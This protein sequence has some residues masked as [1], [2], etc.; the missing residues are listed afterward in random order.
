MVKFIRRLAQYTAGQASC[1]FHSN[2]SSA[3]KHWPCLRSGNWTHRKPSLL[4]LAR[5]KWQLATAA[6]LVMAEA[7]AED[8][9]PLRSCT[10]TRTSR[11]TRPRSN[12]MSVVKAAQVL[13]LNFESHSLHE[14]RKERLRRRYARQVHL[15]VV[16]HLRTAL[17][18][19]YC[20]SAAVGLAKPASDIFVAG[21]LE[22]Y[23]CILCYAS[24]PQ[25]IHTIIE[26]MR[27]IPS[28]LQAAAH[29][30][31]T[32][33]HQRSLRFTELA[34]LSKQYNWLTPKSLCPGLQGGDHPH[35]TS[36]ALQD[37]LWQHLLPQVGPRDLGSLACTCKAAEQL[38]ARAALEKWEEAANACLP[39]QH[40]HCGNNEVRLLQCALI[41]NSLKVLI[42]RV[43][44]ASA[45]PPCSNL[46]LSTA[47][48]SVVRVSS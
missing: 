24:D 8:A 33:Q 20:R 45:S 7:N 11:R 37:P 38:V 17:S 26:I 14:L 34:S 36:Y 31:Q 43:E 16:R 21:L 2:G 9:G 27:N 28:L 47:Q 3:L 23:L 1:T 32:A 15:Y 40:P 29:A 4:H 44:E 39:P 35:L 6:T 22:G 13:L 25:D 5:I 12:K 19:T 48:V 10:L 30:R 41:A 42:R 46:S 18:E